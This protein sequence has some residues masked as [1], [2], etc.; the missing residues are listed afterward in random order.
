MESYKIYLT[1]SSEVS[2]RVAKS[3]IGDSGITD[4]KCVSQGAAKGDNR[5]PAI[6]HNKGYFY[7]IVELIENGENDAPTYDLII[8]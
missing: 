8:C 7:C 6:Y 5:I 3:Y 4:I 2:H 1:K